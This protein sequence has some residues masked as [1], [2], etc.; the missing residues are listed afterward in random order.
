M[1]SN[2]SFIEFQWTILTKMNRKEVHV[3]LEPPSNSISI[4]KTTY[5]WH[6]ITFY[7][8]CKSE[9]KSS[10]TGVT[11]IQSTEIYK[12]IFIYFAQFFKNYKMI[13]NYSYRNQKERQ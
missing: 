3:S 8:L 1:K 4:R 2:E 9:R 11:P 13:F 10:Y 6:V 12:L 5:F 7:N